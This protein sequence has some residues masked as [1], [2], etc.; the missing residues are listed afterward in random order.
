MAPSVWSL[1]GLVVDNLIEAGQIF[2]DVASVSPISAAM[3][4][5]GVLFLGVS[6]GIFAALTIGA[7]ADSLVPS[8]STPPSAHK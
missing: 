7:L 3:L 8:R 2:T 6:S 1:P 4:V 5:M